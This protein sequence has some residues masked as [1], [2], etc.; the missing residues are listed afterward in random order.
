M[1]VFRHSLNNFKTFRDFESGYARPRTG[2]SVLIGLGAVREEPAASVREAISDGQVR[3][4]RHEN[5]AVP[6][7]ALPYR[8][9][10]S[11]D[12]IKMKNRSH[13]AI[14]RVKHAFS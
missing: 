6:S 12:W 1:P 2:R 4:S 14:E 9:G 8:A 7:G 13:P 5:F 11:K 10:R 3:K